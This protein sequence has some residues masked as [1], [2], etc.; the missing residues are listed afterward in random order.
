MTQESHDVV[1]QLD[2]LFE[3]FNKC[4][5][6]G[7]VVAVA[8]RGEVLYR[9]GFGMASLEHGVANTP[10]TRLRIGSTSKHFTCLAALLLAE[11]GKL[12]IDAGIRTYLP[13]LPLLA[14][15]PSL[16]QLMTH[17]GGYR[18]YLDLTL[19]A[20]GVATLPRGGA[21]AA[22]VRQRD[23]NFPPGERMI[24]CNGGYHLLSL[25]IERVSGIPFETFLKERIFDVM[26]MVDTES[27]ADDMRI[28]PRMAT[29]H[30]PDGKGG[31]MRGLFPTW[32]VLGEGGIVSTV[33]DMLLWLAHLR[34]P[35]RVGS[36]ASWR[37]M[38]TRPHYS[39]GAEGV[40]TLGLMR[41]P[42]RDVEV[43]HH[44]GG[45]FGGACQ[46]LTVSEQALDVIILTNGAAANPVELATQVVDIVLGDDILSA[47]PAAPLQTAGHETLLGKYY[48]RVSGT[49]C[50]IGDHNGHVNAILHNAKQMPK[51]LIETEAGLRVDEGTG[52]TLLIK[53]RA[54]TAAARVTAI[55]L[56]DSGLA[57]TLERLPDHAPPLSSASAGLTGT[58][59]GHD[60]A[61][62]A[63][64]AVTNGELTMT[65]HGV[66][67]SV[68]YRLEPVA[69]DIFTFDPAG[70]LAVMYGVL[71]VERSGN[72]VTRVR[73]D[74]S[75]TRNLTFM[76][77]R[78]D[79]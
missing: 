29:Q 60:A 11:D 19:L 48:S 49:Y 31:F 53:P 24:Y 25:A 32:E 68:G 74:T 51:P 4:D 58:Y 65:M 43:L 46:M 36:E 78:L 22:E 27:V 40:Y 9:R 34:G 23:V 20:Q 72:E 79:S 8:H 50:V 44:A 1:K 69:D 71:T 35:K 26:G 12:D 18:C 16:R 66:A 56:V 6:P 38:L 77:D 54:S 33:D 14:G 7:L 67:G 45:V 39:S 30:V 47:K 75:R 42:H 15:D 37:Q 13:E 3:R 52:A 17:T 76:R 63:T 64:I 2:A 62:R 41:T 21:L 10:A 57:E 55:D 28:R 70:Q 61:A 5:E 73:I 59:H